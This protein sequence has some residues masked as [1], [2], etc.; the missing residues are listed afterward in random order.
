MEYK[1]YTKI[2]KPARK[3][4]TFVKII[5]KNRIFNVQIEQILHIF[6]NKRPIYP[7]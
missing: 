4:S 6:S 7:H 2:L 1:T 5:D 3:P